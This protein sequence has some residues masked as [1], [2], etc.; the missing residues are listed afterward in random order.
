MKRRTFISLLGGAAAWPVTARAQQADRLRR[1]G[2]L[3][4]IAESNPDGKARIAAFQNGLLE[5][6][7]REGR[8]IHIEYRWSAGDADRAMA[9]AEELLGLTPDV[10]LATASPPLAA[11]AQK[12]RTIPIV[13]LQVS[14]PVGQG[15]VKSLARPGGN[16][17][18]FANFEFSMMGKWLELLKEVAPSVKRVSLLF[19]PD[20]APY[21]E[22]FLRLAVTAAPSFN[23]ELVV[24]PVRDDVEIEEALATLARKPDGGFIVI[25][26]TFITVRSELI[27]SLSARYRLPAVYPNR[28]FAQS[29]GLMSYGVENVDLYRRAASYVDRILRGEKS[30]D[31]PVQQPT[32][33]E[34]VINIKRAKAL[35]L[36]VPLALQASAD[37]VIE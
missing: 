20:T 3:M 36:T 22:N 37:E 23:V 26:D 25:P 15:F 10:L 28:L 17:T 1:V 35:G 33:F 5:L 19:N 14:D 18:G 7:W 16:V 24:S 34:L 9:S 12:T 31:L 29:G 21:A 32:K 13:F 30:A 11:A 2:V 8:N 27:V 6:G 4:G